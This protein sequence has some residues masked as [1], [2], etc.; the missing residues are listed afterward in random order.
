RL[1][2]REAAK[3]SNKDLMKHLQDVFSEIMP[4]EEAIDKL[5]EAEQFTRLDTKGLSHA[6]KVLSSILG[7]K[8][9]KDITKASKKP[10]AKVVTKAFSDALETSTVNIAEM[11]NQ[12]I[13]ATQKTINEKLVLLEEK[14]KKS[15]SEKN[16]LGI[17]H[18]IIDISRTYTNRFGEDN[19]PS[20]LQ[21]S[22]SYL[23]DLEIL[24]KEL[25]EPK[26]EA[27]KHL[28]KAER[29][30]ER[31]DKEEGEKELKIIYGMELTPEIEAR[32]AELRELQKIQDLQS[33]QQEARKEFIVH[34]TIE[35]E[36]EA[37]DD[38]NIN[39]MLTKIKDVVSTT[40]VAFKEITPNFQKTAFRGVIIL[41]PD[42]IPI[43][44]LLEK[45]IEADPMLTS[46]LI[47]ALSNFAEQA[48]KVEGSL[49]SI[50]YEG[51]AIMI[52]TREKALYVLLTE[53]ETFLARQKLR[54][55]THEI[56]KDERMMR[57]INEPHEVLR[58]DE[59]YMSG[60]I[61]EQIVKLWAHEQAFLN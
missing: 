57:V 43:Y 16:L 46:G 33:E 4:S 15:R 40:M 56:M 28:I 21:R 45:T 3:F 9:E 30:F 36:G 55:L 59:E 51:L 22:E 52:E 48:F 8:A 14:L 58:T 42:G 31:K 23:D 26:I 19:N 1:F 39:Q 7:E 25:D 38:E 60:K 12:I 61:K 13:S 27:V 50:N 54:E 18:A 47:S 10:F 11:V 32:I 35:V 34:E 24:S 17:T 53:E 5:G 49:E 44:Q 37:K 20:D 2:A 41:S 6:T 29:A